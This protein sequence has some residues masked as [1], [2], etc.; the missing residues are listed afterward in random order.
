MLIECGCQIGLT[1]EEFS[2]MVE[3]EYEEGTEHGDTYRAIIKT[4]E[5]VVRHAK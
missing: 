2:L 5:M 3:E 4:I 1:L